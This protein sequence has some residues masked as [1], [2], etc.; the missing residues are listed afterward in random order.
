MPPAES[1]EA[2]GAANPSGNHLKIGQSLCL[3]SIRRS[4]LASG[5]PKDWI[6]EDSL[7]GMIP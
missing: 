5:E 6:E 1:I 2:P 7:R 4:L 3:D